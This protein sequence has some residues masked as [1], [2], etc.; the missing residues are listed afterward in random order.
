MFPVQPLIFPDAGIA[1]G[2]VLLKPTF[3]LGRQNTAA[4]VLSAGAALGQGEAQI[5]LR[6]LQELIGLGIGHLHLHGGGAQGAGPLDGPQELHG[7]LAEELIAIVVG[8]DNFGD[9]LHRELQSLYFQK[10]NAIVPNPLPKS[11]T[12]CYTVYEKVRKNDK[13]SICL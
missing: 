8:E 9:R 12:N 11:N 7:P 13:R 4:A 3:S 2:D 5:G 10:Y 1:I 6:L